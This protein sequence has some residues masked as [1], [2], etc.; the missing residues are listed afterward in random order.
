MR[1]RS[2]RC[3]AGCASLLV[4]LAMAASAAAQA[5]PAGSQF[6]VNTYTTS[7]QVVSQVAAESNGDFVVVWMSAGSS[8]TDTSGVSIHGQR[9]ASNGS[10]L[11]A[12]FQ[13]NTYTT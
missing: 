7:S 9:Y 2:L 1:R 12:Q 8:G 6:Q 5:V 4:G 13:V 10:T 3:S 11:G